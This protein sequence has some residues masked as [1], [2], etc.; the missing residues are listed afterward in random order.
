M[1]S[2]SK[3]EEELL[4]E[5]SSKDSECAID[6]YDEAT[7]LGDIILNNLKKTDIKLQK[8]ITI[9]QYDLLT[10]LSLYLIR[11]EIFN[12]SE[13]NDKETQIL[14]RIWRAA[15]FHFHTFF[16]IKQ[17][18]IDS[19]YNKPLEEIEKLYSKKIEFCEYMF[20]KANEPSVANYVST[21]A[22]LFEMDYISNSFL[23]IDEI[24]NKMK[25]CNKQEK[26][27]CL[28]I[29][30]DILKGFLEYKDNIK[31]LHKLIKGFLKKY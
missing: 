6:L 24:T 15:T 3:T 26:E 7:K 23:D 5:E 16:L 27:L 10:R 30:G 31:R 19:I 4:R 14:D 2:M 21:P 29:H 20:L 8:G 12:S 22:S 11:I 28:K 13:Y 1:I 9:N 18:H 25:N 17:F